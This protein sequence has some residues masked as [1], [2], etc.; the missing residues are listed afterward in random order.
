MKKL[1]FNLFA[2][3]TLVFT[4]CSKDDDSNGTVS[5]NG[6]WKLTAWNVT[7]GVDINNDGTASTNLLQ[8]F[9]CYN[10]ETIVFGANNTVVANSTSY[11]DITAEVTTGTTDEYTFQV[12]CI[13]A[14]DTTPLTWTLSGNTI[15]F[16]SGSPEDVVVGTL[17]GNQIFIAIPEGFEAYDTNTG[18]VV[19][20]QDLVFVYTKQ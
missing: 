9:D 16:D 10:N 20:S 6:T 14:N 12:D 17:S 18:N 19:V 1:I 5:L 13:E 15:T 3:T 2:I 11:A 8:E 7:T 4:S